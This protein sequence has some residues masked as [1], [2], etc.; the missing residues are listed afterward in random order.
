MRCNVIAYICNKSWPITQYAVW[1]KHIS[2]CTCLVF[3]LLF[4][5]VLLLEFVVL[6]YFFQSFLNLFVD[7]TVL[8]SQTRRRSATED[9]NPPSPIGMD[10]ADSFL[11]GQ[12]GIGSPAARRYHNPMTPPSNPHTPASPSTRMVS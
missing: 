6:C 9:D 10:T 5:F 4:V 8:A 12:G 2:A 3:F 11:T 7:D 1:T